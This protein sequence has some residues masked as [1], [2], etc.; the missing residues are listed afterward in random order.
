MR[1]LRTKDFLEVNINELFS[2]NISGFGEKVESQNT[3]IKMLQKHI[4]R[5][6]V[7]VYADLIREQPRKIIGRIG[8]A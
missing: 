6:E 4:L 3:V 8:D 1:C 2:K 7:Q 5:D